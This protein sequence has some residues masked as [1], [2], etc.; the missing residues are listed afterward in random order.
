MLPCDMLCMLHLCPSGDGCHGNQRLANPT[1]PQRW[2]RYW[3]DSYK[4]RGID[5]L[6]TT[7]LDFGNED[8]TPGNNVC[9]GPNPPFCTARLTQQRLRVSQKGLTHN[10]GIGI[11]SILGRFSGQ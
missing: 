5:V 10:R 2:M 3:S 7:M 11:W 9:C 1:G 4:Q 8:Y 6:G